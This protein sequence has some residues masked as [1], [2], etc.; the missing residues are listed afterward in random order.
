MLELL[1]IVDIGGIGGKFKRGIIYGT[2]IDGNGITRV[3]KIYEIY[4]PFRL[5]ISICKRVNRVIRII[6][7]ERIK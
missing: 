1:D 6:L 5:Q 2:V 4:D 3:G 7:N